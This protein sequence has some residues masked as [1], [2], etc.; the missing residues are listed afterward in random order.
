MGNIEI[1]L[2]AVFVIGYL[3]IAL[4]HN[5]H[6]DKAAPAIMLAALLWSIYVMS[7]KSN[8]AHSE[9]KSTH[10]QQSDPAHSP[11]DTPTTAVSA[12]HS[13]VNDVIH[14]VLL[15]SLLGEVA[16]ILFFLI[17]AM[18]IVELIDAH[19]GFEVIT[20]RIKTQ[21]PTSL[22]WI[23]TIIAFFCSA[24]LDNLTT[25]IVMV[26]VLRK[27]I[28]DR[29]VRIHYLSL[30][31]IAANAGGAWTPIGDVTTTM[32]WIGDQISAGEIMKSL[33][34]P[35]L[36]C[37][38]VPAFAM[39][40][41]YQK[42]LTINANAPIEDF[43]HIETN[44]SNSERVFVFIAGVAGLIFVP[45]FKTVTHLPPFMGMIL[46][47]GVL[48]VVTDFMHRHKP[49]K[50]KR[51]LSMYLALKKV[52]V[53]SV[54]FFLGIL[55]AIGCLGQ[56]GILHKMANLLDSTI[57]NIYF[58]A[59]VIGVL[60]AIVDNVP[61]VA[62]AQKMYELA[63][64]GADNFLNYGTDGVFWEY[65]A[66]CAGTGGSC[67]IIGSAAGVAIMGLERIDF[68]WYLR[69]I[70]WLALIGYLAGAAV[71]VIQPW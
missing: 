26:S 32:L 54:M 11:T 27:L 48:W 21:N 59:L 71:Y 50:D 8:E 70:S 16:S 28:P 15:G 40:V 18:A 39:S 12:S 38:A 47:V 43:G 63:P 44:I 17:G 13:T 53:P 56:A 30:V 6:I 68:V 66:Y 51:N 20:S 65:L 36:V 1:I 52:D 58:I 23:I 61:L 64:D 42:S 55:I 34:L 46:S 62:A 2:I 9:H 67:L 3:A 57:G 25:S 49:E 29:L 5:L 45:I 33:L 69:K 4:E 7:F 24:V 31:I 35:S 60:S 41:F 14:H 22:I 10:Y 37:A 19:S